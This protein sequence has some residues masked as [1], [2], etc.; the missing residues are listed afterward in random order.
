MVTFADRVSHAADR[1]TQRYPTVAGVLA[2]RDDLI[3]VGYYDGKRIVVQDS[4][5]LAAWLGTENLDA[6]L[7][8]SDKW[9][10]Q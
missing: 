6:E 4:E 2:D 10:R 3:A 9:A 8:R 5:A 1:H 7:V